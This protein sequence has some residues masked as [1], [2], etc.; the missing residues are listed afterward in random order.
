MKR[1][2]CLGAL[3]V[4]ASFLAACQFA[5]AAAMRGRAAGCAPC[6]PCAS[7]VQYDVVYDVREV[8]CYRTVYETAYRNCTWTQCRPVYK[9]VYQECPD[10]VCRMVFNMVEKPVT[11]TVLK[12]VYHAVQQPRCRVV[13][14]PV[15]T[16]C[17]YCVDQGHWQQVA[18]PACNGC[19]TPCPP[20]PVWVPNI[21]QKRVPVTRYVAR[22]VTETV[23][24]Q[25]CNLVPQQVTRTVR[26][27]VCRVVQ[28]NIV[29]RI[30]H[31]TCQMVTQQMSK[32][33]PYTVCRQVPYTVRTCGAVGS[34]VGPV[35]KSAPQQTDIETR[36]LEAIGRLA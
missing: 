18:A 29:R 2:R 1:T 11:C 13:C 6:A 36:A 14:E 27:P 32:Q 12:P 25:V 23:Q 28:E 24:V 26:Y 34:P 4:M 15:T 22:T 3:V 16:T 30:P 9:T 21:V 5:G 19:C 17:T 10:T 35:T 33:V 31:V 7:C 8:Q 20:C